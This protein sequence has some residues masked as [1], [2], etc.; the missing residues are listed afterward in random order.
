MK[1]MQQL[2]SR[3]VLIFSIVVI[4]SVNLNG[5]TSTSM[6]DELNKNRMKEQLKY[7]E[8][9]TRIYENYRAIRED[10]FQKITGNVSDTIT[11]MENKISGLKIMVL[12]LNHTIDSLRTTLDFTKTSLAEMTRTK[13]S[14]KVLGLEVNKSAYNSTLWTIIVILILILAMGFLSFK[15]TISVTLSTKKELQELKSEFEAYRKTTR[16]AREKAAMDHFNELR[17][18]KGG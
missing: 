13:N 3:F 9:K 5:Q 16:E 15:R 17:K 6:P 7:I 11:T 4:A 14:I 12:S 18:L 2:Q 10:M 8:A 1:D